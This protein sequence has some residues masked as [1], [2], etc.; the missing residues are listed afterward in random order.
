MSCSPSEF[1]SMAKCLRSKLMQWSRTMTTKTK[2]YKWSP[3]YI[4]FA[5][6]IQPLTIIAAACTFCGGIS[7]IVVTLHYACYV[8]I[9]F[10][11]I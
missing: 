10:F 7:S 8:F 2:V 9:V 5:F 1:N 11:S 6:Y 4:L 3:F